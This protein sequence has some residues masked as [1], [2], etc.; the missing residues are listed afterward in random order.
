MKTKINWKFSLALMAMLTTG[1]LYSCNDKVLDQINPN[2]ITPQSF[3]KN[4]D[5]A[6]KG[7]VGVYSPFTHIWNYSR[8]EIF[9]SDY[10]DDVIN[11]YGTSERTDIGAFKGVSISNGTFWVWSTHYQAITRAN[12]VIANVPKIN[13]DATLRD[14]IVGE[15]HFLRAYHYFMLV[16]NWRN[17]PLILEP[18]SDIKDPNAIMQANPDDTWKQVVNDFKMAQAKLPKSWDASNVGRATWGAAR[19]ILENRI[20]I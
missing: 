10:R 19:L 16:N 5:D 1:I 8:F 6:K 14:N 18:F 9:L 7:I 3:W 13:M 4:A 2:S 12:E 15:A 11:A 20:C 17:V